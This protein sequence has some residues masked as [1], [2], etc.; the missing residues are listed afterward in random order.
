MLG[1]ALS[2]RRTPGVL[3][4]EESTALFAAMSSQPTDERKLQIDAFIVSVK[5]TGVWSLLDVFYM[6]ASHDSQAARLNWK[7]PGTLT[8]TVA[9]GSPTF[10]T[11]R[12]YTGDGLTAYI[13]LGYDP[14][15]SSLGMALNSAHAGCYGLTSS[16]NAHAD[17]TSFNLNRL[18]IR[19]RSGSTSNQQIRISTGSSTNMA[20]GGNVP[21]HIVAS[22]VESANQRGYRNGVFDTTG[23]V[24]SSAL[25]GDIRVFGDGTVFSDRQIACVHVGQGL[26]DQNVADCYSAINTYL[27]AVGAV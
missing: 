19:V 9:A 20:T 21:H 25:P 17:L 14:S 4:A 15:V 24:A 23:A 8:A 18:A 16:V 26:T 12:G 6:F 27:S 10:T 2:S 1:L 22:R 3:Y 11:D 7:N 13:S 5:A